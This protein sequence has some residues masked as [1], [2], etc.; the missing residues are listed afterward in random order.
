MN[1]SEAV[2][3]VIDLARK[4]NEYYTAELPKWHPNYPLVGPGEKSAPPPSEEKELR[5][6]LSTLPE[7]MIRRLMLVMYLGRGDIG[8]E[9]L[10]E[11]YE[12][13]QGAFGDREQVISQMMDKALADCLSD[14]LEELLQH[15][16]NVDNLPL[17]RVKVKKR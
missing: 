1:L 10:A 2:N 16:I 4:V 11:Y 8:T 9:D 17:K 14:G 3:R 12:A 13:L 15:K 7:D 6:F 5:V